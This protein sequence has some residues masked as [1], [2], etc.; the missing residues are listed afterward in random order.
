MRKTVPMS[1]ARFYVG[2]AAKPVFLTKRPTFR[3]RTDWRATLALG[4]VLL[5]AAGLGFAVVALIGAV[6]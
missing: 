2:K 3:T 1:N 5:A 6:L 4:L